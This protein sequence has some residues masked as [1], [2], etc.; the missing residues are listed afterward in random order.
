LHCVFLL[1]QRASDTRNVFSLG[2]ARAHDFCN[3]RAGQYL[4]SYFPWLV[5]DL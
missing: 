2:K 4:A 1:T 5:G 3:L